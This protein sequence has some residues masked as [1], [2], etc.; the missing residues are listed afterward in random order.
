M[1]T[2]FLYMRNPYCV[3]GVPS[4]ANAGQIYAAYRKRVEVL[5]LYRF[6]K[7]LH[8]AE[9][10]IVNDML[11]EL[12]G[13]YIQVCSLDSKASTN[14]EKTRRGD[15]GIKGSGVAKSKPPISYSIKGKSRKYQH[16][17]EITK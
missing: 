6:D 12:A 17:E 2:E 16:N 9:R 8:P 13:A 4:F 7:S 15:N 5:R 3:L 14:A 1:K 11:R 10:Q